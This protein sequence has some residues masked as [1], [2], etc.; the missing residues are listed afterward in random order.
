M[1]GK[2]EGVGLKNGV[3]ALQA[4]VKTMT[5]AIKIAD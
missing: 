5:R 4:M 2:G 3:N 1:I